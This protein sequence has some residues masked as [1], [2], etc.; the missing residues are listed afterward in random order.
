[1]ALDVELNTMPDTQLQSSS[2]V[3]DP[4]V[5]AFLH[6]ERE[7]F[8]S[9]AYPTEVWKEDLCDIET[10]HGEAREL[11]DSL[12]SQAVAPD[13]P[14][15]VGRILLLLG[16]SGAGKTHLMRAFRTRT[17]SSGAGYFGYMQMTSMAPNYAR[18]VLRMLIDSLLK[19]YSPRLMDD[20]VRGL[21]RISDAIAESPGVDREL[22][23]QLRSDALR[24]PEL[25]RV[26]HTLSEQILN[27]GLQ[28]SRIDL[29][30][31]LLFLQSPNAQAHSIIYK[32][33]RG[34]RIA[35]IDLENLAGIM[36]LDGDDDA[37][38]III[39]LG[40]L[41]WTLQKSALVICVDQIEDMLL[42][43]SETVAAGDRFVRALT[44]LRQISESL[45]S[46]VVVVSCLEDFYH[47]F[48]NT[49]PAPLREKIQT[50]PEPIKL[51]AT[52]N[53]GE[54]D[55]MV[56]AHLV[57]LSDESNFVV[58]GTYPVPEE[59]LKAVTGL[60]SRDV[61]QACRVYRQRCIASDGLVAFRSI[62]VQPSDSDAGLDEQR[63]EQK[64]NDFVAAWTSELL[65]D[66]PALISLLEKAVHIIGVE[67]KSGFHCDCQASGRYLSLVS[68]TNGIRRY[69]AIC[70]S[71]PQGGGLT[72]QVSELRKAAADIPGSMHPI[73]VRTTDYRPKSP[74]SQVA[75]E[76]AA[77]VQSGGFSL[78]ID[79]TDWRKISA[80]L[81]FH[82]LHNNEPEFE[83]WQ[84]TMLPLS[85]IAPLNKL[86]ELDRI[87]RNPVAQKSVTQPVPQTTVPSNEPDTHGER[88][89]RQP[90]R[91]D[92][93]TSHDST[94][95]SVGE[96]L[97]EK[98][99]FFIE[100][101]SLK[102]HAA[103]LGGTNSGKT[104]A[105]LNWIEQ[106]LLAGV[107]VVLVDRKGDLARFA[108]SGIWSEE[109]T[110]PRLIERGQKLR[111]Q[112]E[113][114]LFTPGHSEG[115]PLALSIV[116]DGLYRMAEGDRQIICR[117]AADA[118][119]KLMGLGN[120]ATAKAQISVLIKSI[121]VLSR[122][123]SPITLD[124]LIHLIH[125]PDDELLSELGILD[126]KH[127]TKVAECLQM[128]RINKEHL[129]PENCET[130]NS[131]SLFGL[132]SHK[133]TG[134]TR[135]SIISTKFLGGDENT[136][137]WVA[138]LILE[139]N[140]WSSLNPSSTL[141][142]A[143]L[144]D[145]A[146]VYLPATSKP[147]TKEPIESLLKRAR[148]AG[149]SIFLATQSPGDM[150]YKCRDN[151]STWMLGRIREDRALEKLKPL[152]SSLR[153]DISTRLAAQDKGHF[154]F[155]HNGD[156]MRVHSDRSFLQTEQLSEADILNL[157]NNAETIGRTGA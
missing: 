87:P 1:M 3:V 71:S 157:A 82:R 31:A 49:L 80:F 64:W 145:E 147:A 141:Q 95:I 32:F 10:I 54:V 84:Q 21:Q 56:T 30:R 46:A 139:L 94:L 99:R 104:T 28:T 93:A 66:D 152:F 12:L 101:E 29:V 57:Q 88:K 98:Q 100:R 114:A 43:Q 26:I 39:G 38:E 79:D 150:D 109:S 77:V 52:R 24:G 72:R 153:T 156:V 128:L 16:E 105:A 5:D 85:R 113:V 89:S 33:L 19:V 115:R 135:L 9:V 62:T 18:Y 151:I 76:F 118:L 149:L 133:Q 107:P 65:P 74:Q 61:L 106:L 55:D 42:D 134:K 60:R 73:I 35:P 41:M 116:P 112:I 142:A 27:G 146:D 129:F 91:N 102:T 59:L 122:R 131:E 81:E 96:K 36:P 137:F 108:D 8:R 25:S 83:A 58:A 144:F 143:V 111:Q 103:F 70:N 97:P 63:L 75:R 44:V 50:N 92:H 136:L 124:T 40:E 148:S 86:L 48:C 34:E 130:L 51:V 6:S 78:T 90:A 20:D 119:A 125:D 117:N 69:V 67:Q 123:E 15:K 121:E 14:S 22:L 47:K 155:C 132:G 126:P 140:R 23:D 17:H 127:C 68:D 120:S 2:D 45:P 37:I 11:F 154:Y 110:D 13:N 4:V 7:I 138:Q 53:R